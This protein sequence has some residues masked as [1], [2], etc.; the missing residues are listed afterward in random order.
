MIWVF[1]FNVAIMVHVKSRNSENDFSIKWVRIAFSEFN[2]RGEIVYR[3]GGRGGTQVQR[4]GRTR[5]TYL[6]EE[7]VFFK[8]FFKYFFVPWYEV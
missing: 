1:L 4:G 7:G 3:P 5:V 2:F 8:Y 6:A